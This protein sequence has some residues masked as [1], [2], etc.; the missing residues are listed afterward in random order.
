MPFTKRCPTTKDWYTI[1]EFF[2]SSVMVCMSV[3]ADFVGA[4]GWDPDMVR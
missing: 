4:S 1:F 2:S 3:L